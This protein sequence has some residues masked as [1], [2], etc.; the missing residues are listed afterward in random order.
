MKKG[1]RPSLRGGQPLQFGRKNQKPVKC[2]ASSQAFGSNTSVA[3]RLKFGST[4]P[5]PL[6]VDPQFRWFICCSY[7][8]ISKK[9]YRQLYNTGTIKKAQISYKECSAVSVAHDTFSLQW[10]G[11]LVFPSKT[12]WSCVNNPQNKPSNLIM[13][14]Q[15]WIPPNRQH[16]YDLE[17]FLLYSFLQSKCK[18]WMGNTIRAVWFLSTPYLLPLP[19]SF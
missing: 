8:I 10:W 5:A 9:D 6:I 17:D 18:Q 13:T 7:V 1:P 15:T 19:F 14:N 11:R 12:F 2:L 16:S 3:F 4:V